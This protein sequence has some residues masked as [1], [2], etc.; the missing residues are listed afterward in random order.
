MAA[1]RGIVSTSGR[2]A[3]ATAAAVRVHCSEVQAAIEE[4]ICSSSEFV[5]LRTGDIVAVEL[6][7]K[8]ALASRAECET[9][10]KATFCENEAFS[11]KILF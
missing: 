4:A 3:R 7:P 6:A 1:I 9:Q 10:F 2:T 8:T 11:F 5:S